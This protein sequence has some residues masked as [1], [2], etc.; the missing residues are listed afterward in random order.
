MFFWRI[1]SHMRPLAKPSRA[2][3][4][5]VDP[6]VMSFLSKNWL[7]H[8]FYNENCTFQWKVTFPFWGVLALFHKDFVGPPG[9]AISSSMFTVCDACAQNQAS[10]NTPPGAAGV[11]GATGSHGSHEVVSR[12]AT[13]SPLPTRAGGQDDGSYTH[14]PKLDY[15]SL[16]IFWTFCGIAV[17]ILILSLLSP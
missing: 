5:Y 13:R 17:L 14:S 3:W 12:T 6:L 9:I 11:T 4:P 15:I 10:W 16:H 8:A 2:K 7:W 1:R